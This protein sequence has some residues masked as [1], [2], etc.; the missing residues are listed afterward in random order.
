[1]AAGRYKVFISHAREDL[2]I[3]R[4][5]AGYLGASG[6]TPFVAWDAWQGGTGSQAA[7]VKA[8]KDADELI[9]L[10]SPRHASSSWF[11]LEL[12]IAES[13]GK[14][15]TPILHNIPRIQAAQIPFLANYQLTML[16]D[17]QEYFDH[18]RQRIHDKRGDVAGMDFSSLRGLTAGDR[19][20]HG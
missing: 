9:V 6:A 11:T 17:V 10:L 16:D 14:L 7:I 20:N 13:A 19:F 4:M 1:M 18:L 2:P 8:L 15:V 12:G 5:I 3:A